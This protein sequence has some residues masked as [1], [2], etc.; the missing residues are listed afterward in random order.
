MKESFFLRS[1]IFQSGRD[2]PAYEEGEDP[3]FLWKGVEREAR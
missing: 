2:L 1:L 3:F